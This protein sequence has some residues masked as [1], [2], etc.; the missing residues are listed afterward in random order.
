MKARSSRWPGVLVM[1]GTAWLLGIS[2]STVVS[3]QADPIDPVTYKKCFADSNCGQII[4]GGNMCN[5][6][7][8]SG[9]PEC[10]DGSCNESAL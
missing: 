8:N 7:W 5:C 9:D 3:A 2:A 6:C 10:K 4:C 1:I